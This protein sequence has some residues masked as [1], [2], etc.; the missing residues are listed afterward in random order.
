MLNLKK[1]KSSP[2]VANFLSDP[3]AV[4]SFV[5]VVLLVLAA[6]FAP[7]LSPMNPYDTASI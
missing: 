4:V 1:I 5:V 7:L 3:L 2:R 6:A